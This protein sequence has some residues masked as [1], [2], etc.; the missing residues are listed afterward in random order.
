[1]TTIVNGRKR[2]YN[3]KIAS[4]DSVEIN[5]YCTQCVLI[6]EKGL[7]IL[8]RSMVINFAYVSCVGGHSLIP[9]LVPSGI[10]GISF[11]CWHI[12]FPYGRR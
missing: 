4:P 3:N 11:C 9:Q 1:M 12:T 7:I 5:Q 10:L 8:N 2:L 6:G